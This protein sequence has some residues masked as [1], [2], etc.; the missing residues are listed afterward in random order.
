MMLNTK[1]KPQGFEDIEFV[2]K[3][4]PE[5]NKEEIDISTKVFGKL[6]S[7]LFNT[8]AIAG[9]HPAAK[10]INKELAIAIEEKQITLGVGSQ[11]AAIE[12]PSLVD[13]YTIVRDYAPSN[14]ITW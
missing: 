12:N 8:F 1:I 5:I 9:G 7:P 10:N 6:A 4:L 2:H 11:R 13:T 14:F 3:A